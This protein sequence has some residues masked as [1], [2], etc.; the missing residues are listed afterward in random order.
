MR[1]PI[2]IIG[3]PTSIGIRPYDDGTPRGLDRAPA[4]FRRRGLVERVGAF[5]PFV[6]V[7]VAYPILLIEALGSELD[8]PFGHHPNDLPLTRICSTIQ[9]DLLGFA[10]PPELAFARHGVED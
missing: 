4:A 6:T 8:D 2:T 3:A 9:K 7:V 5:T 1:R 10:P